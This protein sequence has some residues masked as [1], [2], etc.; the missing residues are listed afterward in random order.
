[1]AVPVGWNKPARCAELG[2]RRTFT[3]VSQQQP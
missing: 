3:R 2:G 1:V